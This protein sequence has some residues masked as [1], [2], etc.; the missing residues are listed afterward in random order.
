MKMPWPNQAMVV[1][2]ALALAGVYSVSPIKRASQAGC[3]EL[4]GCMGRFPST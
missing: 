3:H 4:C 2:L 1:G